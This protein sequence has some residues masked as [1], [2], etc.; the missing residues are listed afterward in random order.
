[1]GRHL[2][3]FRSNLT[4]D[5]PHDIVIRIIFREQVHAAVPDNLTVD[6]GK[7]LAAILQLKLS[8]VPVSS[9]IKHFN[10]PILAKQHYFNV[11]FLTNLSENL[12]HY[13]VSAS[14]EPTMYHPRKIDTVLQDWA[15]SDDRRPL[16]L[17]GARQV[18]KTSAVRHLG[19]TFTY[20]A[21]IDLNEKT[22]LHS[23][24]DGKLSPQEIV[25]QLSLLEDVTIE[26]GKTLLFFDE[27]QACPDAINRL[28]YFYER[29]PELH[30]IA[31][32]SLLEFALAELPSFGV[33]RIRSVF[34]YPF[35]FE[36]FLAASGRSALSQAIRQASP[37]APL[38][39]VIHQRLIQL[40]RI[41]LIIGGMPAVIKTYLEN[42]D[43]KA[44]REL[45][46]DLLVSYRDDFKK[47]RTK[48]NPI[49]LNAVLDAVARQGQGKCVYSKVG[50]DVRA[51]QGKQALETLI[52][53]GLVY[54]VTHT[55]ANG[56]PLGAEINPRYRRM[57]LIDT[58]I[59]LNI[60]GLQLHDILLSNDIKLVNRGGL[61]ETFVGIELLKSQPSSAPAPLYCWHREAKDANAEVDYVIQQGST[62]IPIEVKSGTRGSMHSLRLF[63][64]EKHLPKGIRVSLENFA[65]FEDID[66]IP[67]Y[68][69]GSLDSQKQQ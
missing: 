54:P 1:M 66:V 62:I 38:P 37:Q 26:P 17:R 60:L 65:S 5:N 14:K 16:L 47:Y 52:L 23:L 44:C 22:Y 31:A 57:I 68:A 39:D 48:V 58:G 4:A 28:R 20:F 10:M 69:V 9:I 15:K 43:V 42:Q 61:A 30:V 40:L 49:L 59:L 8:N 25:S 55:S 67:L 63:L 3:Q 6:Y 36:E 24:F 46:N 50:Q 34:M 18:G 11:P 41:F 35:S 19:K 27:I 33:G 21:D 13:T 2:Q 7:T 45:L 29:L 56:I 32:G 51:Q 12:L 64:K 53:A